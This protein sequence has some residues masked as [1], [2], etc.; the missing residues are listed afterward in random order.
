MHLTFLFDDDILRHQPLGPSY[1]SAVLK[2][3][4]HKVTAI[5]ID[6]DDYVAKIQELKPDIIASSITSGQYKRFYQINQEIKTHHNCLSYYGG[7]HPTFF[8]EMIEY[9]GTDIICSGEGEY[10]TLELLNRMQDGRDY[11]D[12]PSLSFNQNGTVIRNDNRPFIKQD[13]LDALPFPDREL[14][15]PFPIWN[16]RTGFVTAGRGCPY[17][18][19]FCFNHVSMKTQKG[20]WTRLRSPDD[21]IQEIQWLKDRYKV[22]LIHFQDDTFILNKAWL[23]EFLPRYRDEIQLPFVCNVRGDLTNPEIVKLLAEAGCCRVAMGIESGSDEI[24]RKILNKKMTNEQIISACDLYNQYGIKI[25]GQNIFGAPGETIETAMSTVDL[26]IRCNTHIGMFS[27]FTPYPGTKLAE[28][29]AEEMNFTLDMNDIPYGYY[30]HLPDCIKL[31]DKEIIE[32]IGQCAQLFTSYPRL[33][34][35]TKFILKMLP[36]NTLKLMYLNWLYE[37]KNELYKKGEVGL[38]SIWHPPRFVVDAMQDLPE[39]PE[40]PVT[41]AKTRKAA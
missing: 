19:S 32:K 20:R 28:T 26:N 14:I 10:P 5:N 7:P 16:Q 18:C 29:A 3:N 39:I 24:R 15:R 1:I 23:N 37:I 41:R 13:S 33:W 22:V 36:T 17:M 4:G 8:P 21:V 38:P 34:P 12:I 2:E 31:K 27:F 40:Q 11:T 6:Q 9:E 30:D 35:L 25:M